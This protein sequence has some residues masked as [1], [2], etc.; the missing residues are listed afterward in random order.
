MLASRGGHV[1]QGS[2]HGLLGGLDLAGGHADV[3]LRLRERVECGARTTGLNLDQLHAAP[4]GDDTLDRILVRVLAGNAGDV[5]PTFL[6]Q[7][8]I[9]KGSNKF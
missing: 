7:E 3:A 1:A 2:E 6:R 4:A 8:T 9:E 5:G